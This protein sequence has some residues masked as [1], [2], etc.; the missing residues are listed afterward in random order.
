MIGADVEAVFFG[1]AL[2]ND[3]GL[4]VVAAWWGDCGAR[5]AGGREI[6]G[7]DC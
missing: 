4:E 5:C 6:G 7:S 1:V 3:A 2:A